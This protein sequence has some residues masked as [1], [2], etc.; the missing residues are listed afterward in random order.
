[1]VIRPGTAED[2]AAVLALWR[3]A[4]AVPGATDDAES[5]HAL[6]ATDPNALLVAEIEQGVV[7]SLIAAWDGWRG[8]MYRLAV[9]PE[10][11]RNGVAVALV[12]AGEARL[13]DIGCRRI[14]ALVVGDHDHAVGFWSSVGYDHQAGTRRY[15]R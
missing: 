10:H 14:T 8:N 12:R 7:G 5:L 4:G 15:V 9:L 13:R 2:V 6:I 3:A 1:M 11:R